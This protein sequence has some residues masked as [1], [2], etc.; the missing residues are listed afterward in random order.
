MN[1]VCIFFLLPTFVYAQ[2][3]GDVFDAEYALIDFVR[4]LGYFFFVLAIALFFW[5]IV[6]FISNASDSDA[7][8]EGKKFI[9][10]SIIAFVVLVSLWGIV[11]L[12]AE[13]ISP[14][15]A[16]IEYIDSKGMTVSS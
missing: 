14:G 13:Y 1:K 4:T 2:A 9:M 5:G 11:A 6:K 10:W 8:E 3:I 15:S 16:P 7:R 12:V